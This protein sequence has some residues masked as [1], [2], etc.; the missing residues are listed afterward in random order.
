MSLQL[1]LRGPKATMP[2]LCSSRKSQYESPVAS[3][4][5]DTGMEEPEEPYLVLI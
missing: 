3:K 4:N 1:S 2:L 5:H